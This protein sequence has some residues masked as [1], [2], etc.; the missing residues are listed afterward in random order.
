ML[1]PKAA[2]AIRAFS[3]IHA[4]ID[5]LK[6][7]PAR[8]SYSPDRGW[9]RE[10]VVGHE[11]VIEFLGDELPS[12]LGSPLVT[13]YRAGNDQY[14]FRATQQVVRVELAS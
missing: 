14:T 5:E 13:V 2:E 6:Q 9:Y 4:A 12:E 11:A 10:H 1:H 7:K 3:E 8:L